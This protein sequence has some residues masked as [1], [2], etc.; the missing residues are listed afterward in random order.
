M[1]ETM[2]K[3][4]AG[5]LDADGSLS[6]T[7]KKYDKVEDTNF[8]GLMLS[9]ASS[10]AVDE[11]GFIDGLPEETGMGG[12]YRY[13]KNNQ[14]KSWRISKRSDLEMILPRLI[15]HMV[16]KGKHWQWL[17]ETWREQRGAWISTAQRVELTA[18]SQRSR[19]ENAGPVKPK[20]HPT[21]AW[22]AGY[23][24]GD[25]WYRLK[26]QK[27]PQN[28]WQISVGAVAHDKDIGVLQFLHKAFG[29][30]IREQGQA[31]NV[32]V[33]W[34]SL[35][36]RDSSFALRFLPNLVKHSR[37]KRHKIEQIIAHH[38]QQRLSVQTP[39]GEAI[40]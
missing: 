18:G 14:F 9:L 30:V 28:Y 36:I 29:G 10:D 1:N 34:R 19:V 26:Y 33:W 17:F 7:F 20:N 37:L 23:L 31:P 5:L 25:G 4:L 8:L 35:G 16:I 3:Y 24:D 21:W 12:L 27:P 39:T 15:K 38:H 13:G 32:K 2:I 11:R 22:L 6:F 40:V